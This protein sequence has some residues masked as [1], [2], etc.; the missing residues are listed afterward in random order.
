[1]RTC[2]DI[3]GNKTL[4]FGRY[5]VQTNGNL[6]ETHRRGVCDSTLAELRDYVNKYGTEKQR[7]YLSA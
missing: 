6:P 4:K 2:T 1:M 7:A 5:S 3:N